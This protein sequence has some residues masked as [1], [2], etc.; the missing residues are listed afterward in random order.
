MAGLRFESRSASTVRL[1]ACGALPWVL[2]YLHRSSSVFLAVAVVATES[3]QGHENLF[4][5]PEGIYPHKGEVRFFQRA[6]G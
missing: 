2:R 1:E 5:Y 4:L 6:S 3:P